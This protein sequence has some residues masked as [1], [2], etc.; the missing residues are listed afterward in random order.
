MKQAFGPAGAYVF[1]IGRGAQLVSEGHMYRGIEAMMPSFIKNGMKAMRF[2]SEGALTLKGDP[3][4]DDLS[5]YNLAMQ[6]LG[7]SPANLTRTYEEIG[8]MKEFERELLA[9]RTQLL[10]KYDMA[11]K[12]GDSEL[13][14][15]TREEIA[16]FNQRR[17][18][19]KAKITQD[20]LNRSQRSRKA[21]EEQMIHGIRFNK[22]LRPELDRLLESF[23]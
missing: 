17:I 2:A 23:E 16:E 7:F 9:Q 11:I 5:G 21:A 15:E 1:D 3:I 10:N 18:N 14:Q 13:M 19:P 22:A 8:M 12:S 20:T 6:A 4:V